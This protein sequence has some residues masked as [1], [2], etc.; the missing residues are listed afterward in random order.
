MDCLQELS[1]SYDNKSYD[2]DYLKL[3][4]IVLM[5]F[6]YNGS[7]LLLINSD[8]KIEAGYFALFGQVGLDIIISIFSFKLYKNTQEKHLKYVYLFF[9]LAAISATIADGVYHIAMNILNQ[10]Y[11]NDFNSF[12]EIPFLLFL[13]FQVLAWGSIFFINNTLSAKKQ[14]HYFPYITVVLFILITF[15]YVIPWKIHY[16]SQL[17][18]YQLLDTILEVIGFSLSAVCLTRSVS[19]PI[20]FMSIGYLLIISSDLFIRYHVI[21]A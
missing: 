11:F 21:S 6:F 18:L 10:T 8:L 7:Y 4:F 14:V 1:R 16:F 9:C 17:G 15:V 13:F 3:S 20:R 2:R 12:F 5:S 19:K